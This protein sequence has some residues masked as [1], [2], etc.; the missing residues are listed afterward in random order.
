MINPIS[1]PPLF[2]FVTALQSQT[3]FQ[4]RAKINVESNTP[5][6]KVIY[7]I[8]HIPTN[9]GILKHKIEKETIFTLTRYL[10]RVY[11]NFEEISNIL[12]E[13]K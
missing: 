3:L 10:G 1:N 9:H 2:Y 7:T 12:K 5:N 8:P 13:N 11:D 6:G 4:A